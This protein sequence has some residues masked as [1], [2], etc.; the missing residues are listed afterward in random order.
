[1]RSCP[2]TWIVGSTP[3]RPR[4][5]RPGAAAAT[6]STSCGTTQRTGK[7]EQ[8]PGPAGWHIYRPASTTRDSDL[9]AHRIEI[10]GSGWG[11]RLGPADSNVRSA[12][13]YCHT[14]PHLAGSSDDKAGLWQA[15][16]AGGVPGGLA[17]PALLG[18]Q[19]VLRAGPGLPQ[20]IHLA[21]GQG[22]VKYPARII[23]KASGFI[24]SGKSDCCRLSDHFP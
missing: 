10:L 20:A 11:A 15:D 3:G 13:P 1:M 7:F 22:P 9:T 19:K 5:C 4:R 24:M 2:G 6:T 8:S 17:R 23:T 14:P 21:L 18:G 16:Y 12:A